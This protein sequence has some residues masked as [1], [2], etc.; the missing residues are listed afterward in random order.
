MPRSRKPSSPASR[1]A[2]C[3]NEDAD[4]PDTCT[5]DDDSVLLAF[6]AIWRRA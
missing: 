2:K 3:A 5:L 6:V 1:R 4:E